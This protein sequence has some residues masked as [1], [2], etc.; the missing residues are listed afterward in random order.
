MEYTELDIRLKEVN[1][2]ADILVAKLNEIEFESY[3]EDENGVKAYVQT[4]LLN[5]DAVKE[6][7]SEISELTELSF[8]ISKVKQENW[9]AEWESNYTPVFINKTCVIRAHFH[10]AFPDV[11]HEI[12]ITP[13]MSFGTGHHETTS[14]MM[15]EMLELNF[16]GKSVLDMGSGTGVL[17][18][19]ASKLGAINL[20]GIDFDKWAFKNAKE[21][22]VLNNISNIHLIHGDVNA[23]GNAKYDVILANI[24]RNIILNDIEIYIG[25]MAD[26]AI[27]LLS[28]FLEEDIPLILERTEQLGLQL[29]VSK[30]KNKWQF[31]YLKRV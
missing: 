21:N 25:A 4:Q 16:K 29:V 15:N 27:I 22:T 20:V 8:T 11:R 17:A 6:I 5:K 23:I 9:N 12:I 31:L 19:L 30:N 10:N 7:I 26:A 28:G 24:N 13:K 2:F 14:L 3:A 18:I 1:H